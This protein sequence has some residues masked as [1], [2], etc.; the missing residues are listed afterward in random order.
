MPF[1][2]DGCTLFPDRWRG[3][4]LYPCCYKHDLSWYA[5]PGDWLVWWHSNIDLAV[6]VAHAG[7]TE[8]ALPFLAAVSTVGALLFAIKARKR[9]Q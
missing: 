9:K 7:A 1:H 5:H 4:D 6:C 2:S 3:V 8:L